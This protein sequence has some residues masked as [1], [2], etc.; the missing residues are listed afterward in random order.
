MSYVVAALLDAGRAG[1]RL[2]SEPDLRKTIVRDGWAEDGCGGHC[3]S[4]GR[5]YRLSEDDPAFFLRITD[6]TRND[7]K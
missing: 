6:H 5:L 7:W 1:V 4:S 3:R 2:E